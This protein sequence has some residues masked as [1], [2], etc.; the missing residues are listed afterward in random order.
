VERPPNAERGPGKGPAPTTPNAGPQGTATPVTSSA[1][2]A[3]RD[4]ILSPDNTLS[5]TERLVAVA[6]SMHMDRSTLRAWPGP[7]L[8]AK[9]TALS[10]SAVKA[11][12]KALRIAGWLIQVKKGGTRSGGR[13]E[14]SIYQATRPGGDPVQEV[15]VVPRAAG[16]PHPVQVVTPP[17]PGGGQELDHEPGT[18]PAPVLEARTFEGRRYEFVHTGGR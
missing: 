5:A 14:P 6:L 13:L 16:G 10:P 1:L 18:Q 12:L 2:Y 15:D 7:A 3:W 11:A 8:L 17:R 9:R 4:A